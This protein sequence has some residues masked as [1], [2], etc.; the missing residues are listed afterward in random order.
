MDCIIRAVCYRSVVSLPFPQNLLFS[1]SPPVAIPLEKM[2]SFL[3]QIWTAIN[4]SG[5]VGIFW[6]PPV[7]MTGRWRTQLCT[8]TVAAVGSWL[9]WLCHIWTAA[10]H[11]ICLHPSALKF[12]PLCLCYVLS[13]MYPVFGRVLISDSYHHFDQIWVP[14]STITCWKG[15]LCPRRR[16]TLACGHAHKYLEGTF[17]HAQ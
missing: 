12:F 4:S 5:R 15:P 6:A 14:E 13:V 10:F 7:S 8:G 1:V 2:T 11:D 9:R 17:E 3:W 16:A